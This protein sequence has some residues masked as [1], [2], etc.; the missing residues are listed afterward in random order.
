MP[1]KK[2]LLKVKHTPS[3]TNTF[4]KG[5]ILSRLWWCWWWAIWCK[6][7][8]LKIIQLDIF[9]VKHFIFL[10]FSNDEL[11]CIIFYLK[12]PFYYNMTCCKFAIEEFQWYTWYFILS[13]TISNKKPSRVVETRTISETFITSSYTYERLFTVYCLFWLYRHLRENPQTFYLL[14]KF[15]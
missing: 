4:W 5:I 11:I 8:Y 12:I 13:K 1:Q 9:D 6:A 14:S 2:K 3:V 7:I 15:L 10:F